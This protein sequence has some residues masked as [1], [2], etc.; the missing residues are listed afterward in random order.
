M[1]TVL[2][3]F[4][5]Q[6]G[7]TILSKVPVLRNRLGRCLCMP[8]RPLCF[9]PCFGQ[10]QR[11]ASAFLE[12][13]SDTSTRQDETSQPLLVPD[14]ETSLVN[15][16]Q[17]I[18]LNPSEIILPAIWKIC[19]VRLSTLSPFNAVAIYL[20]YLY[21]VL[22]NPTHTIGLQLNHQWGECF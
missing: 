8:D 11:C 10:T 13:L 9:F 19:W 1:G 14:K 20:V 16:L 21:L 22:S 2:H 12:N 17:Q 15:H 3:Y 6:Q 18:R 7:L 5:C 4:D